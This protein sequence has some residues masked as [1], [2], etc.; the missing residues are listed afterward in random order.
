MASLITSTGPGWD[1]R[2]SSHTEVSHLNNVLDIQASSRIKEQTERGTG[3]RIWTTVINQT[4][5][6]TDIQ[7]DGDSRQTNIYD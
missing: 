5:R 3:C 1:S 4:V 6:Q 2:R 7:T